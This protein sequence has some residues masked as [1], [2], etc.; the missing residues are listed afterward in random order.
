MSCCPKAMSLL[1]SFILW[2]F[3]YRL[4]VKFYSYFTSSN[5]E[6]I[7]RI[8]SVFY[9][10]SFV[11]SGH[12]KIKLSG[13]KTCKEYLSPSLIGR[14]HILHLLHDAQFEKSDYISKS[15]T[16]RRIL[17]Y[18]RQNYSLSSHIFKFSILLDNIAGATFYKPIK[19]LD[20]SSNPIRDEQPPHR[21]P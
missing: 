6:K 14:L 16:V 8:L 1:G 5:L 21:L 9:V 3:P 19:L 18:D 17:C 20:L 2:A 4:Q 15:Q 10:G 11:L 12:D 13:N 7:F